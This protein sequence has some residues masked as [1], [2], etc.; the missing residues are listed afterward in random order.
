MNLVFNNDWIE[1]NSRAFIK[2]VFELSFTYKDKGFTLYSHYK[3]GILN[4]SVWE[5][6]KGSYKPIQFKD[7]SITAENYL[8]YSKDYIING[9]D[10]DENFL[11]KWRLKTAI[12]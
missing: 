8:Q 3:D 10:K 9:I 2:G 12:I 1:T 7:S 6:L 5:D 4:L 11:E